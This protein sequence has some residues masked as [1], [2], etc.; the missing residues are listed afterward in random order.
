[1]KSI[2]TSEIKQDFFVANFNADA[3]MVETEEDFEEVLSALGEQTVAYYDEDEEFSDLAER[4]DGTPDRYSVIYH[5]NG[6]TLGMLA[7]WVTR[8]S[9]TGTTIEAFDTREQAE[10]AIRKYEDSDKKEGIYES[11]FYEVAKI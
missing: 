3:F 5:S 2:K 7:T 1:M 6:T 9:A 11:D 4:L 8:D 10:E